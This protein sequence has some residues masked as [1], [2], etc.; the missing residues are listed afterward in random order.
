MKEVSSLKRKVESKGLPVNIDSI[1]GN[2]FD[3]AGIRV[4]TNYLNDVYYIEKKHCC[5]KVM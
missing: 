2:I 1:E 5:S 3:I 4:V